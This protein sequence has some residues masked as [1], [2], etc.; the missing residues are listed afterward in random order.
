MP[1]LLKDRLT[2]PVNSRGRFDVPSYMYPHVTAMLDAAEQE[3]RQ[4]I[5]LKKGDQTIVKPADIVEW[6]EQNFRLP[7]T[8]APVVFAPHQIP[9]LRLAFTR[10]ETNHFPYQVFVYSTIKQSGKSTIAGLAEQW[11]AETGPRQQELYC[12]GNDKEQAKNRSFR[13][14]RYSLELH[15]NYDSDRDRI[16]GEWDLLKESMRCTRTGTTIRALAVDAKGEAGGKPALQCWTELWGYEEEGARRFWE[17]LTPIP[18]IPDSMRI[19][20]TYAGYLNE[21]ELLYSLYQ[22]GHD[23]HQL[24]AGELRDRT[25]CELGV[26]AEA[27]DPHDLVPI[28]ENKA[29]SLLMYWDSGVNARRM[30]WQLDDRGKEYY[31]V[32]EAT[33]PRPA[34]LR[35]HMNEWSSAD[36]NFIQAEWWDACKAAL[37]PLEPG[38]KTP[39]VMAV[40]AATTGDCFAIVLVSRHPDPAKHD[41]VA[42][43]RVKVFDPKES[44]GVVSHAEAENLIRL[45]CRGGCFNLHARSLPHAGQTWLE[46]NPG[47]EECPYCVAQDFGIEGYN[48]VQ[49]A[50]DPF[51]LEGMMQ[52]LRT[53]AVAWCEPFLQQQDR[54]KADRGLYDMIL[55]RRIHHD[56]DERLKQ[57]I[58]NAGAKVQKDEDSTMRLIKIAQNRKIDAAVATSMAAARCL[59]LV[60]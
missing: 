47:Q 9:I 2:K 41:Q 46:S 56:G 36:T 55:T 59:Y 27:T 11:Y 7:Q 51:Q 44:G 32:Q 13:E 24:T 43:R 48:V 45:I 14:I 12:I 31:R 3:I 4:A 42:V 37:E 28:W 17:E 38:D 8:S 49:V 34:W 26:F 23:G 53:D 5:K 60:I 30:P 18:T 29:T 58:L 1:K 35:L 19:V 33:L 10:D 50:Y 22:Q 25:G 21:S 15:P 20:E 52:R 16:P 6:A 54:L 40:D 57:H 39:T